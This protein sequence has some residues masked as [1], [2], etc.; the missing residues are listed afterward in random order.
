M[1]IGRDDF[2]EATKRILAE[3]AGWYCSFPNCGQFTLGPSNSDQEKRI[4]NGIAAHICAASENG[5]RYDPLM[6]PE[7]R[8]SVENG[9][10]MCRNHGNLIDAD[11]LTYSVTQ[12]KEWKITAENKAYAMLS[13]SNY[14]TETRSRYSDHDRRVFEALN[15]VLSYEVIQKISDDP[16]GGFVPDSVIQP[17]NYLTNNGND[18]ILHF[19]NQELE[20]L[21]ELL[22]RQAWDFRRYFTQQSAGATGG[23]EYI[24]IREFRRYN[25]DVP[26]SHWIGISE[27]TSRLA[28]EFCSTALR[29]R[30]MQQGL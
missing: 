23:Y 15:R 22:I 19:N 7:Q 25:P 6:T 28:R 5:P 14:S 30:E 27:E 11:F 13:N 3:R 20:Q 16:F 2:S 10:W 21:R 24:N 1:A 29:L 18:P 9:I 17:F 8:R 26:E 4:N 12:L